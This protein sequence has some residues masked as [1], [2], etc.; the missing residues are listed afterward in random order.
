MG[1]FQNLRRP[2]APAPPPVPVA[3]AAPT[4]PVPA[5]LPGIAAATAAQICQQY[6]PQPAAR[7]LLTPQQTPAQYLNALQAQQFGDDMIR[8]LAYGLSDRDGVRW[9]AQS[10]QKVSASLQPAEVQALQTAQSYA[11]NPTAENQ[12]AAAAAAAKTDHQGPGAWAAQGAAWAQPPTSAAGLPAAATPTAQRLTPQAVVGAVML[13]AAI[14]AN[15]ALAAPRAPAIPGQ[16]PSPFQPPAVPQPPAGANQPA[17]LA[18]NRLPS[19]PPVPGAPAAPAIGAPPAFATPAAPG[20]PPGGGGA[21]PSAATMAAR[22]EL[23]APR[24]PA[25]TLQAPTL[26]PPAPPQFQSPGS[27]PP[28]PP[29]TPEERAQ[30]FK[31]QYPFIALGIAIASGKTAA[32]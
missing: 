16:P 19:L 7:E 21:V 18:S 24:V 31:A 29:P 20:L 23:A 28:T 25:P 4:P 13:S 6:Q 3:V 32:V 14:T 11:R 30:A 26:Q 1:F 15:P 2:Q 10:A 27:P 5:Q 9:A 17:A 22:P 12:A 8:V